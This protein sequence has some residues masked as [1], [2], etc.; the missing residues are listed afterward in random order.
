MQVWNVLTDDEDKQDLEDFGLD[1]DVQMLG[2]ITL[3]PKYVVVLKLCMRIRVHGRKLFENAVD[4]NI[5][6]NG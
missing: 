6:E 4:G 1:Q 2:W 5:F 3:L